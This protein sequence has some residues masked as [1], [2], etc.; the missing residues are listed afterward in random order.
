MDQTCSQ[1]D[2]QIPSDL[3]SCLRNNDKLLG[4]PTNAHPVRR[5]VEQLITS[6]LF[7]SRRTEKPTEYRTI[8]IELIFGHLPVSTHPCWCDDKL[9]ESIS[10]KHLPNEKSETC[11][12]IACVEKGKA[13]SA[14]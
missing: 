7:P 5:I 10:T 4:L 13:E 1:V 9:W 2:R 3:V 8:S 14:D 6:R 11:R 12:E